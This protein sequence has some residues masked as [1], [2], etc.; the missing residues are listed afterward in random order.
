LGEAQRN[1]DLGRPDAAREQLDIA[2]A[3]AR[4]VLKAGGQ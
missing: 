2:E 1:L 4:R 3:F